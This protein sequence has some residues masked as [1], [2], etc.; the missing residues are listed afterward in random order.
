MSEQKNREF[1]I[2]FG[3][4]PSNDK[5]VY[6]RYSSTSPFKPTDFSDEVIHTIE[7][8]EYEK[9]IE[10][11]KKLKDQLWIAKDSQLRTYDGMTDKLD[12]LELKDEKS[13]KI[14]AGLIGALKTIV[15]NEFR[16]GTALIDG[17][18]KTPMR[19]AREAL[20][21]YRLSQANN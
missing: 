3:G 18:E 1:W 16:Y 7:Y 17:K 13:K 11:N 4:D 6:K 20:E 12:E 21:S 10:E 2:E 9:I 14:I 19:I 15:D 8:S 5:E